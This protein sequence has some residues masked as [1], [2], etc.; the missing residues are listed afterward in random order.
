M[1]IPPQIGDVDVGFISNTDFNVFKIMT[2][3]VSVSI[4]EAKACLENGQLK[5]FQNR[6]LDRGW[7]RACAHLIPFY[8]LFYAAKRRTITPL[9][10]T[11]IGGTIVVLTV[12]VGIAATNPS[13]SNRELRRSMTAVGLV[14]TPFLAKVG[15]ELAREQG[16]RK[17]SKANDALVEIA[18]RDFGY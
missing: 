8:N 4:M 2:S 5:A 10:C 6:Q 15:I 9:Y 7:G 13:I 3:A 11:I 18:Y 17:I 14:S 12:G 16:K 1:G